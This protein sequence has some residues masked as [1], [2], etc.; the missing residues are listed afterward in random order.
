[1]HIPVIIS[2][3]ATTASTIPSNGNSCCPRPSH[4]APAESAPMLAAEMVRVVKI[5][6]IS[7]SPKL[8]VRMAMIPR[9]ALIATDTIKNHSATFLGLMSCLE[10]A[11]YFRALQ[12]IGDDSVG[13][14][15]IEFRF[16]T[17]GESLTEA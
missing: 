14:G 9:S 17:Q 10:L 6:R 15:A 4:S 8:P 2:S 11:W 16:G 1:N 7:K 12:N 5:I 13:R 3:A